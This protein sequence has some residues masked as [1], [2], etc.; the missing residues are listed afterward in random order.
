MHILMA[1]AMIVSIVVR[2]SV[3][4]DR[5]INSDNYNNKVHIHQQRVLIKCLYIKNYKK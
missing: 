3:L 1:V 2:T 4:F 5:K